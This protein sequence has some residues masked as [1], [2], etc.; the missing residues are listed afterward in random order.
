MDSLQDLPI[1]ARTFIACIAVAGLIM[2]SVGAY[3]WSSSNILRFFAY[4]GLS[5]VASTMKVR[6]P[7]TESTMSASFLFV[8]IGTASFT[9]SE[10]LVVGCCAALMQTVWRTKRYMPV[11][12]I[13]NVASWA[14]SITFSYWLSHFL[15]G[16]E[17]PLTVLLPL[18]AFLFFGSHTGLIAL[19][20]S[21]TTQKSFA[22]TWHSCF[23]WSFPYYLFG[24]IIATLWSVSART[25]GWWSFILML[26]LM[27]L[28]HVFYHACV[29]RMSDA[30]S[31]GQS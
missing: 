13:F 17:Q 8:L 27:Y 3:L 11:Q 12:G 18:S 20:V 23:L 10:T 28:S 16:V 24:A 7:G 21:S 31:L 22:E 29:D 6:L 5:L 2:L 26:P 15:C 1:R 25:D 14:I 9:L 19:V 4:L 30:N